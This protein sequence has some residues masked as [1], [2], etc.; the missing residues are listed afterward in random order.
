[1]LTGAGYRSRD[2]YVFMLYNWDI[3]FAEME[4]KRMKCWEWRLQ[5]V[6]CRYRPLDQLFD[7]Y[8]PWEASQTS[9]DYYIHEKGGWTDAQVKQFRRNV[10]QQNICVRHG[11][12]FYSKAFERKNLGR[13]I[14]RAVKEAQSL[15]EKTQLLD[16][17][18]ADYWFPNEARH[19]P[20]QLRY[21]RPD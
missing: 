17:V 7:Q 10:R 5:I 12:P 1:M 15:P 14:R 8:K 19:P 21:C 4:M 16:G 6:D 2:I 13:D 18:G 11:F 9:S 3:P 20:R